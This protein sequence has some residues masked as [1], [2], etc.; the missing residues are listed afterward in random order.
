VYRNSLI[1]YALMPSLWFSA[2]LIHM[3]FGPVYVAYIIPKML[4]ISAAHSS[5]PWDQRLLEYR[6]TKPIMWLLSR[7]IST[8]ATHA[9]H[10]GRHHEDGVTH[11][12]GNFG[13]FLFLWDVIFG[14]AKITNRRPSTFGL[15]NV[16]PA[17]WFQELIWPLGKSS[18]QYAVSG[19]EA[20]DEV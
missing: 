10:H 19:E 12:K 4:V 16:E 14:T 13:N 17:S 5:V 1:Y 3:G 18:Q 7:I 11:Y 9:A 20:E 15:E 6:V 8:P 2:A